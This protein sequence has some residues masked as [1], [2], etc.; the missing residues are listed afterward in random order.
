[1]SDA[2]TLVIGHSRLE[3]GNRAVC[4]LVGLD[5]GEG[6]AGMVVNT[7]VDEIP[8]G[9]AAPVWTT[10]IAGEAVADPLETPELFDVDV[11]DL[12]W[13]LAL[14]AAFRLGGLQIPYP[15]Q[16]QAAQNAADGGRRHLDL[17]RDC[18]PVW[19]CR[20]K[21]SIAVHVVGRVWLGDEWGL[22]ERSRNPSAPSA[23]NRLT[24]LATVFGV[25]LNW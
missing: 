22:E 16:A 1:V 14:I 25:V 9:A 7:D 11:N 8:A 23:R 12:A 6:D 24:H 2:E 18:L 3:K 13:T 15:I 17:G 5:L 4:R 10:R 19:R 20:R 21:A